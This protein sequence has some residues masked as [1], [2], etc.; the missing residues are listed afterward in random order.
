VKNPPKAIDAPSG[1]SATAAS[2]LGN[3]LS[4][5]CSSLIHKDKK[6]TPGR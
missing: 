1:I 2:A 6:I 5:T 4:T 3:T